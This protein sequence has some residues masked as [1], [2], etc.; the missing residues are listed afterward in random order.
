MKQN[1]ITFGLLLLAYA[2]H[3]QNSTATAS[4]HMELGLAEVVTV[5]MSP[6][7][8]GNGGGGNGSTVAMPISGVN[9]MTSGVESAAIEVSLQ[10]TTPFAISVQASA[11]TF[12]YSGSA[13]TGNV[14]QVKDVLSV[15]VTANNTGG[16]ISNGFNTYQAVDGTNSK[17]VIDQGQ[18]GI[19][20]FSFQ[21]KATPGF[22][23][24]A[25]T[26][27]TDIIYTISKL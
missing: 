17:K 6:T 27:T 11:N 13:T 22:E 25:G 4:Q 10:G 26:Y 12:T 23:Y 1:I 16:V 5:N 24:A 8:G 7:G 21:Y 3:A 15:V 14:M 2:G 9:A 20:S 19:R 18:P